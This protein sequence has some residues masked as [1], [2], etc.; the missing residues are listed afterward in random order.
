MTDAMLLHVNG[1][2]RVVPLD[3]PVTLLDALQ[4]RPR[5]GHAGSSSTANACSR[6]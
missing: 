2:E 1:Q 6:A 3:G 4:P 5:A